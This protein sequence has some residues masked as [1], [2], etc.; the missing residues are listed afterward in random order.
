[1]AAYLVPESPR[2]SACYRYQFP[3]GR[4]GKYIGAVYAGSGTGGFSRREFHAGLHRR[5][6][7]HFP[8]LRAVG[9][10]PAFDEGT[11]GDNRESREGCARGGRC[12][13]KSRRRED[14]GGAYGVILLQEKT[15]LLYIEKI[16]VYI[17]FKGDKYESLGVRIKPVDKSRLNRFSPKG[18]PGNTAA[19]GIQL[20]NHRE[21]C[22]LLTVT[23][24]TL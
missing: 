19:H 7:T 11:G 22:F 15:L 16:I 13:R 6:G 8:P 9:P 2:E 21:R 23:E 18:R 12:A 3:A 20:Q 10:E 17:L 1:V 5:Y 4:N 14:A 24:R